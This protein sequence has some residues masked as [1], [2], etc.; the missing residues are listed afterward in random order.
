MARK[1]DQP[2]QYQWEVFSEAKQRNVSAAYMLVDSS[3]Y[4]PLCIEVQPIAGHCLPGHG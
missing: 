4:H 3:A 1:I 2:R